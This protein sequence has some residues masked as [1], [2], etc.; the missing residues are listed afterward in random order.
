VLTVQR[1]EVFDADLDRY[2]NYATDVVVPLR[3]TARADWT[4]T[5]RTGLGLQVTHYGAS[6]FFTPDEEGLGLVD[7]DAVTLVAPTR[8]TTSVPPSCTSPPTT[9]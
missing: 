5:P 8:A 4:P 9:C 6:S 1:G 3:I 7:T 2:I